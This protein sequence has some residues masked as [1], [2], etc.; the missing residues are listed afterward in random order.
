MSGKN[1]SV[2]K[3]VLANLQMLIRFEFEVLFN[4]Y[5]LLK[6]G[7]GRIIRPKFA[8]FRVVTGEW[9]GGFA[10]KSVGQSCEGYLPRRGEGVP[11]AKESQIKS[12]IVSN[13]QMLPTYTQLPLPSHY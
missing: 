8:Y 5:F 3:G 11:N 4:V 6:H 10:G 9:G 2:R 7:V 12:V 13:K 1:I